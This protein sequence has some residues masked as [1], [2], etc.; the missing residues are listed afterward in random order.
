M[1]GL[2][3]VFG[4]V[5]ARVWV[6]QAVGWPRWVRLCGVVSKVGGFPFFFLFSLS[7]IV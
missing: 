3:G 7:A 5:M 2:T 6:L 4:N 1:F